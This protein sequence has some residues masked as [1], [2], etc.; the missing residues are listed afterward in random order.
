MSIIER[1]FHKPAHKMPTAPKPVLEVF[2]VPVFRVHHTKLEAY[3][4][5]VFGFEYDLLLG[6]GVTEGQCLEIDVDGKL[7]GG[8]WERR[9]NELRLGTRTKSLVLI[10]AVLAHDRYIQPGKYII[11]TYKLPDP[12]TVYTELLRRTED[13]AHPDCV[14]FKNTHK[15]DK[16]FQQ[17][18]R[19]LDER[20]LEF[21]K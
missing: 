7:P 5:K 1:N 11:P 17:R 2:Q 9:A 4:K 6:A 8:E 21:K 15:G 14:K 10:L 18:A 3:V 19:V 20:V 13:P 12:T 16:V